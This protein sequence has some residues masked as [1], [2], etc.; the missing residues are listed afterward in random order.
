[1]AVAG[2]HDI[3]ANGLRAILAQDPSIEVVERFPAI[4][5]IPDVVVYDAIGVEENG[6]AELSQLVREFDSAVVVISRDLRPDLAVRA[7]AIGAD[8]CISIESSAAKILATIQA[9]S[10]GDLRSEVED[11]AP[12]GHEALLSQRETDVLAA[13]TK[14]LSNDEIAQLLRLSRN[15]VKTY[16]RYAYRKINVESRAQA[17][18]WCLLH[19]FEPGT[20][21]TLP[22]KA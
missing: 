5:S 16:I 7:L 21:G 8:G 1:V 4:K 3:V 17:V 13:V 20:P 15:T 18:A 14:G 12:P 9:A 19:G 22:P 6:G 2:A 10:Q 11:P